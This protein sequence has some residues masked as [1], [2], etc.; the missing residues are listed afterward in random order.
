MRRPTARGPIHGS[1]S[2]AELKRVA[3]TWTRVRSPG[4]RSFTRSAPATVS[5]VIAGA[6]RVSS[7]TSSV[8][9]ATFLISARTSSTVSATE[10]SPEL[11]RR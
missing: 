5:S 6:E 11:R 7:P 10:G 2:S 4:S 1:S 8:V 3:I 9:N